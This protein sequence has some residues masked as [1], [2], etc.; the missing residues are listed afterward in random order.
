[1]TDDVWMTRKEAAAYA[2]T[3]VGTL[4]TLLYE[5]K[6]PRC[7]KPSPKRVLYRKS[8]LDAWLMGDKVTA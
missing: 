2:R 3:T 8:D 4:A 5:K 6:G 1:M 7:Y